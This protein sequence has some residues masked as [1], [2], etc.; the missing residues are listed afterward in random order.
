MFPCEQSL[1]LEERRLAFAPEIRML[2]EG[3]QR[4]RIEKRS[5]LS[6]TRLEEEEE[7]KKEDDFSS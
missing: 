4:R 5:H 6:I 7:K 3:R 1:P 2:N